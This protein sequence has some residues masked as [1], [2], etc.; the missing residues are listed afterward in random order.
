M[1]SEQIFAIVREETGEKELALATTL[2][3]LGLD[4]LGFIDLMAKCGV[5]Q[6]KEI[7]IET[8]GDIVKALDC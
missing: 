5:P 2:E 8:V 1:T 6:E 4:S 7:G 3:S